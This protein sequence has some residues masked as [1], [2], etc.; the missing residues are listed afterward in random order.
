MPRLF[1]TSTLLRVLGAALLLTVAFACENSN[2]KTLKRPNQFQV[3]IPTDDELK[4]S[5]LPMPREFS[6]TLYQNEDLK[7]LDKTTKIWLRYAID[8]IN[9]LQPTLFLKRCYNIA[10]IGVGDALLYQAS[11]HPETPINFGNFKQPFIALP[12]SNVAHITML[13]QRSPHSGLVPECADILIGDETTLIRQFSLYNAPELLV[14]ALFFIIGM[15]SVLSWW[16]HRNKTLLYSGYFYLAMTGY[17]IFNTQ[18]IHFINLNN[19]EIYN[20]WTLCLFAASILALLFFY[21]AFDRK[22]RAFPVLAA[23]NIGLASI[24]FGLLMCGFPEAF[25]ATKKIYL[26]LSLVEIACIAP[27]A[28]SHLLYSP[29][30]ARRAFWIGVLCFIAGLFIDSLTRLLHGDS[31]HATALGGLIYLFLGLMSFAKARFFGAYNENLQN[32]ND[33]EEYTIRLETEVKVREQRLRERN[34]LLAESN[35]ELEE[36]NILLRLAFK[37]LDDLLQ[38]QAAMLRKASKIKSSILPEIIES[39][40]VTSTRFDRD[41]LRKLSLSIHK[42]ASLLDPFARLHDNIEAVSNKLV[43]IISSNKTLETSYKHALNSSK[44]R[45]QCFNA[46]QDILHKLKDQQPNLLVIC[47]EHGDLIS[48]VQTQYPHIQIIMSGDKDFTS[49]IDILRHF[50]DLN[51]LIFQ[52]PEP[53]FFMQRNL[54]VTSTK[55]LSNDVFGIEKYLDWGV[56]IKETIITGNDSRRGALEQL[57]QDLIKSGLSTTVVRKAHHLADELLM[58]AI[59]DAPVDPQS[60][61]PRYNHLTRDVSVELEPSE[62]A[63]LRYGYDGTILAL[64]IDDPFGGLKR[65]IILKYLKAC[66]E[67]QFGK[68][69]ESEG[70]GGGGMGLYQIMTSSDLLVTNIKP[71]RKTEIITLINV[72]E[73][74]PSKG[75]CFHYFIERETA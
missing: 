22:Y 21:H 9:F 29:K 10:A 59:Y 39:R 64:S 40:D 52:Q 49:S 43:W 50:S 35:I 19:R 38:Q 25:L 34:R 36:K 17:F 74:S 54:L 20:S 57:D 69:N 8:P 6:D 27:F 46:A 75:Q 53:S 73:K 72:H 33:I 61:I 37:R 4:L 67:G 18:V 3:Y 51:H 41:S 26:N 62:Y 48:N 30:P 31:Y 42:L 66:L 12:S 28:I 24:S 70:K 58:N 16:I 5:P 13:V 45:V 68:I 71:G 15:I 23:F 32:R 56:D 65:E 44:L 2:L 11:V 1:L 14:G 7:K 47:S 55:I 60:K 63:R